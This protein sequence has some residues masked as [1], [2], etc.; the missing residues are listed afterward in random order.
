MR[1]PK[2]GISYACQT[3]ESPSAARGYDSGG[4]VQVHEFNSQGAFHRTLYHQPAAEGTVGLDVMSQG[5]Y[6]RG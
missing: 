2:I 1:V 4:M 5:Q 6:L 3:T